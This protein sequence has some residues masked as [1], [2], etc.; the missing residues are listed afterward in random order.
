M[1]VQDGE[2]AKEES[3]LRRRGTEKSL[4]TVAVPMGSSSHSVPSPSSWKVWA[5]ELLTQVLGVDSLLWFV[6]IYRRLFLWR[7]M[8]TVS[9]I[10]TLSSSSVTKSVVPKS[11]EEWAEAHQTATKQARRLKLT[12]SWIHALFDVHG[13]QIFNLG[14]FN[15]DPHPGNILI[16]EED[17]DD[18]T[19]H[20]SQQGK[21]KLPASSPH[22]IYPNAQLGLIDYGQCKRLTPQE[23]VS[24]AR[25]V[26]SVA[27]DLP[28]HEI[29]SAFRNLGIRTTND[30]TEFL[31]D[32]AR[33][34]FG[35][36]KPEHLSHKWHTRLHEMD[37]ILY[38]PN[39]LSMVYRTSLLLRGL[40]MWLQVNCSVGEEWKKHAQD[41]IDQYVNSVEK[42]MK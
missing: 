33:L 29:A 36:L 13:H 5:S 40:G 21:I 34:M 16:I 6:R 24:V 15:A 11:W 39:E 10:Q 38:F 35:K 41:S 9:T 20:Q 12:E 14:L 19:Q 1:V 18:R 7:T 23:R 32:F 17:E 25:L 28:D 27:N 22:K 37:K 4:G 42:I 30:S 31:A 26:L 8:S 3:T 2:G